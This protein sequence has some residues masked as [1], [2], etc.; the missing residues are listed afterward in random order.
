MSAT[1]DAERERDERAERIAN[2]PQAVAEVEISYLDNTRAMLHLR[3]A[4]KGHGMVTSICAIDGVD[5]VSQTRYSLTI[6]RGQ[7]F[8][9]PPIV[10]ALKL[11]IGPLRVTV[12]GVETEL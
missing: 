11:I 4:I 3:H 10:K 12:G 9:W 7:L 1:K 6:N 5:G 2:P 8:P